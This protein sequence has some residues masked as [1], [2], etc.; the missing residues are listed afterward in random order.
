MRAAGLLSGPVPLALRLLRRVPAAAIA[1]IAGA[2]VTR[3][4]W[5]R[6]GQ[7]SS[8]DPAPALALRASTD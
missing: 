5:I 1:S 4:A 6:A 7:I 3:F 8:Q 2:L